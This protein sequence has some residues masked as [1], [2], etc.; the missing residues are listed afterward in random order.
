MVFPVVTYSCESWTIKKAECQ[1]T[2]AFQCGGGE[3]SW[4]SLRRC[5]RGSTVSR[6]LSIWRSNHSYL[7]RNQPW[8]LVGRTDA[9]DEAPVFWS[10]D[11]NSQLTG[12][13]PDAGK[14]WGQ[15][16]RASEDEM[17]GWHHWCNGHQLGQ[18]S[19]DGEGQGDLACW[20]STGSQKVGP[21]W[22]TEQQKAG[23]KVTADYALLKFAIWY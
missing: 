16:K 12:K 13:V 17:A 8:I 3:D 20:Q 11:V 2:D 1:R 19:G 5:W 9:K 22:V 23:A 7:K 21:D 10:S 6:S 4:K 14:D 18:T 15:K